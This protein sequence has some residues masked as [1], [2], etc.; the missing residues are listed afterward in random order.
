MKKFR[1]YMLV[2]AALLLTCVL[3]QAQPSATFK[4]LAG[5]WKI[6]TPN[7]TVMESWSII[8]DSTLAGK[9]V[10]IKN[11]TDTIPQETIE[12]AFRNGQW[13]YIPAVQG[14]NNN[15]PVK[16]AVIFQKGTEFICENPAHDFPQRIAYRRINKQL[17]A[18][19]EGR[20]NGKYTKVNF[21]FS[22]E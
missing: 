10:F 18:S 12:L 16:L 2:C 7:G 6:N 11:N 9:S 15:Q 20:R 5:K 14:Q 17:F 3:V 4:W 21:D 22:H 13:Y 19:I 1:K 8:N